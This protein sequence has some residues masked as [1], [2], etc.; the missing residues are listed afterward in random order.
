M[1]ILGILLLHLPPA[2]AG[3]T[4]PAKKISAKSSMQHLQETAF[5]PDFIPRILLATSIKCLELLQ[6]G[7]N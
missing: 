1:V 6:G 3:M 4:C 5:L 2:I 7:L